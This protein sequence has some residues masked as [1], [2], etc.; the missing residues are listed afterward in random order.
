M[1][2]LSISVAAFNAEKWI[3]QCLDSFCIPEIID[4]IEVLVINDGSTDH[5]KEYAQKYVSRYPNSFRLINK[6]NGGHGSTINTGIKAASGK[7]FKLV[8]ADDWVEREGIIDLVKKAECCTA[9]AIISP[10]YKFFIT[11]K[12]LQLQKVFYNEFKKSC[13]IDHE[14]EIEKVAEDCEFG[15]HT[16]TFRTSLLKENFTKITENCFYVDMEYDAFYSCYISKALISD[17]P[18]YVYRL[19]NDGQSIALKNMIKRREQHFRVCKKL[20]AKFV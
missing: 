16:L 14:I 2:T 20:M 6:I 4:D 9:D 7:Y 18:V 3:E 10:Y 13:Y 12:D 15:L 11:G 1:K 17:V 8:D 19:G 5:T